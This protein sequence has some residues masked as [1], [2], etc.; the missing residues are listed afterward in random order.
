MN[1]FRPR[2]VVFFLGFCLL[3][4]AGAGSGAA[5]KIPLD[6]VVHPI[7]GSVR[8]PEIIRETQKDPIYPE[9]WRK[10]HLG[11]HVILQVV[12]EKSGSVS[13]V[14]PLMVGLRVETDCGKE[15]TEPAGKEAG[16][17]MAPPEAGPDFEAAAINAVKQW[18]YRPGTMQGEP[19]SVFYTVIV[20]FTSCPKTTGPGRPPER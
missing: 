19:V 7:L 20:D 18:K 8:N 10:H 6:K 2:S 4:G 9:K 14:Q 5:E 13:E 3:L 15:P 1:V 16:N 17:S 11:A 12:V